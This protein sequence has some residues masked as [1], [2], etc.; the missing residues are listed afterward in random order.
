V[1]EL[2]AGDPEQVGGYRLLRRLGSGGMGRVY[3]GQSP[4]GRLVAV[5][6]IRAEFADSAEFRARFAREVAAA[7]RVS[8]IFTAPVVDADTDGPVPWLVTAYVDGPSLAGVVAA[9][10][11][12]GRPVVLALARGLAEGLGA[13]HAAGVVHRDLKPSNVLLAS[14]GPRIID[15]GISRAADATVMTHA[16]LVVGS[17]GFMS[18]EQASGESGV[19][20]GP[21]SDVFSLGAVLAYAATGQEPFGTGPAYALLYRVVHDPAV[22]GDLTGELRAV[23]EWCLNK[24]PALRPGPRDL[25]ARL[26]PAESGGWPVAGWPAPRAPAAAGFAAPPAAYSPA[27]ASLGGPGRAGP[28]PRPV[29]EEARTAPFRQDAAPVGMPPRSRRRSG[30]IRAAIAAVAI[31]AAA[32]AGLALATHGF[33]DGN[34]SSPPTPAGTAAAAS[35]S[36]SPRAVVEAYYAAVNARDWRRVWHL[37][38]RNLGQSYGSMVAG[39]R[40]TRRDA[41]TITTVEGSAVAAKIRAYETT[42]A[43]QTY[44]LHY[45]VRDG[46]ITSGQQTLLATAKPTRAAPGCPP[47]RYGADG[48]AGPLFCADGDP[49]PPVLAYYQRLHLL[50]LRLGPDATGGRVLQAMCTDV[51]R[52]AT[53]PIEDAAYDLAQRQEGWSFRVSPP[54]EMLNGAC[55][56]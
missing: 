11:A 15:F 41:L 22:L 32:G 48:T 31:L 47:I 54:R 44:A 35:V 9:D 40:L 56:G 30:P 19:S 27:A 20:V 21:A 3:L 37:G 14:D 45:I 55:S 36:S 51:R 49:N 39:F 1:E 42:G 43:V 25:L 34:P 50:V 52:R 6:V 17:P 16:G 46:V 29:A 7:R 10:G 38:G 18:P 13:I 53:Y 24:D 2:Q 26:G 33:G 5:K 4:G 23:I 28:D 12:V 8:S